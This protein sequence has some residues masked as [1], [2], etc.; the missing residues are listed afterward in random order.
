MAIYQG[1]DASAYQGVIDWRRVKAHSMDFAILR[2]TIGNGRL[3]SQTDRLFHRNMYEAKD[4]GL[5]TGA[6]HSALA[7]NPDETHREAEGFLYAIRDYKLDFP[8]AIDIEDRSLRN[9]TPDRLDA[10]VRTWCQDLK[11]AGYYPI[12]RAGH[13]TAT[14]R[15]NPE[16]LKEYDLWLLQHGNLLGYNGD[17]G[18]WQYTV[19][20]S[21]GGVKTR[22]GCDRALKDYPSII[23]ERGLNGFTAPAAT[24][25][26]PPEP[27]VQAQ[28]QAQQ[29]DKNPLDAYT[30]SLIQAFEVMSG[31]LAI[32]DVLRKL[33]EDD[34]LVKKLLYP[35]VKESKSKTPVNLDEVLEQ[36]QANI[37]KT[38]LPPEPQAAAKTKPAPVQPSP[39]VSDTGFLPGESE[40]VK[41]DVEPPSAKTE[42]TANDIP[43]NIL[44]IKP[45]AM[46]PATN[47]TIAAET[48]KEEEIVSDFSAILDKVIEE[49]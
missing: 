20:G 24:A 3:E 29:P 4:A 46:E 2:A 49:G 12:I 17:V 21:V 18:I 28:T 26:E 9:L 23:R 47:A 39:P 27:T 6:Y 10:V 48:Q 7:T 37:P 25:P 44:E 5:L 22:I 40:Q 32:A 16:T 1:V 19:Y 36:K 38:E 33:S 15:L 45:E 42:S 34:S 31:L 8:V 41:T 13:Y 14:N 30:N 11:N 43:G 35:E